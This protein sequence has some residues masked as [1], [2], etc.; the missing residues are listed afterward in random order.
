MTHKPLVITFL[1]DEDTRQR[2]RERV[3]PNRRL[4]RFSQFIREGIELRL[5]KDDPHIG[6]SVKR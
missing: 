6:W 1:L 2:V 3:G 5:E 4:K